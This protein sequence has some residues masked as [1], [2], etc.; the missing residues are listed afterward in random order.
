MGA[1]ASSVSSF[2]IL[3]SVCKRILLPFVF[4]YT[5]G[6]LSNIRLQDEQSK[7]DKEKKRNCRLSISIDRKKWFSSNFCMFVFWPVFSVLLS[8]CLSAYLSV[9]P[10]FCLSSCLSV[11]QSICL[12]AC[13]SACPP[14]WRIA[15]LSNRRN[16]N[17]QFPTVDYRLPDQIN[18]RAH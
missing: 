7:K 8:V 18:K 16:G 14:V 15:C 11:C 5:I 13:L 12:P 1:F 9:Y 6:Q 17:G 10:P 3:L 2:T 4:P